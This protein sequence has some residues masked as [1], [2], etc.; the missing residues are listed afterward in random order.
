MLTRQAVEDK[1]N[2]NNAKS[3]KSQ[4]VYQAGIET[5]EKQVWR[6]RKNRRWRWS[7]EETGEV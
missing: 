5:V 6:K 3:I 7:Y 1:L 2:R 4:P